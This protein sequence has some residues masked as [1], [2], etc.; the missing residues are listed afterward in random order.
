MYKYI[1]KKKESVTQSTV[2]LNIS[3]FKQFCYLIEATN[4]L[5]IKLVSQKK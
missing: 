4:F 2:I 5:E 3:L 1:V